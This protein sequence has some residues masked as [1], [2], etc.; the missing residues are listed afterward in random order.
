MSES[1]ETTMLE[2]EL[3]AEQGQHYS[4]IKQAIPDCLINA[5]PHRRT[6]LKQTKPRFPAWYVQSTSAQKA[7]IK[8]LLEAVC[9]S[10]NTLDKTLSGIQTA[11]E[12]GQSLLEAS[13]KDIGF[14][15]PVHDVSVRLYVPQGN[16]IIGTSGHKVKTFT[17]LQDALHN[18]EEPETQ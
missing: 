1:H 9:T 17:V 5:G 12:F 6:A 7:H 15:L 18:Y 13:L 16:F 11:E 14:S 3:P 2:L 10:Q 8:P 4:L